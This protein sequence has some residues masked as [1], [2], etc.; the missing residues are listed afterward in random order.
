MAQPQRQVDVHQDELCPPKKC[1]ALIDGNKKI[2]LDNP[3]CPNES[4]I[5]ANPKSSTQIQL[6]YI[7]ISTMELLGTVLAY[8]KRRWIK[9]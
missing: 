2:D 5:M 3:M 9:V 8:F 6:C 4:K 7:I 1:N